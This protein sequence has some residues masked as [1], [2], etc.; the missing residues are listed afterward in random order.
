M[1]KMQTIKVCASEN[2][3]AMKLFAIDVKFLASVEKRPHHWSE[4]HNGKDVRAAS[5]GFA[6]M[7]RH[8]L[9][10]DFTEAA[11]SHLS[12]M[13]TPEIYHENST[14]GPSGVTKPLSTLLFGR[15]RYIYSL[16]LG[17]CFLQFI[18]KLLL[19]AFIHPTRPRPTCL[20]VSQTAARLWQ[21]TPPRC[22]A[23][24]CRP[25]RPPR[26]RRTTRSS[27]AT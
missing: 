17:L 4:S 24:H 23:G 12:Q 1:E 19:L 25:L 6:P 11:D 5:D 10:I 22:P 21:L 18:R 3:S 27:L 2:F 8:N 13:N 26:L 7:R 16:L 9:L 20:F 15:A 14:R